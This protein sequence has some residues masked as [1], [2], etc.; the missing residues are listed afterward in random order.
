MDVAQCDSSAIRKR[1]I[2]T[3]GRRCVQHARHLWGLARAGSRT[4]VEIETDHVTRCGLFPMSGGQWGH[5]LRSTPLA[6]HD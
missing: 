3:V 5:R 1:M 4:V 6:S 2:E